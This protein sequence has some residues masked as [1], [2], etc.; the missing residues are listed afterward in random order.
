MVFPIFSILSDI[1]DLSYPRIPRSNADHGQ[2]IPVQR[3]AVYR[4]SP[5]SRPPPTHPFRWVFFD[6]EKTS[7]TY[8]QELIHCPRSVAGRWSGWVSGRRPLPY[9]PRLT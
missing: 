2:F 1:C 4:T 9:F 3:V 5:P 7:V 6:D 8:A